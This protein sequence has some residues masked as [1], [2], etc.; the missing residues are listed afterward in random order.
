M[1]IHEGLISDTLYDDTNY[2]VLQKLEVS[3]NFDQVSIRGKNYDVKDKTLLG[4]F[5]HTGSFTGTKYGIIV[6]N[7]PVCTLPHD[8]TFEKLFDL[9]LDPNVIYVRAS[10]RLKPIKKF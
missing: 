2:N 7:S 6:D 5:R 8:F 1:L 9:V 3:I 10:R 4:S